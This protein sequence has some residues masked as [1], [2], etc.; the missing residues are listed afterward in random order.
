MSSSLEIA[1]SGG[2]GTILGHC[3]DKFRGVLETFIAN[4]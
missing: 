3:D 2:K 1:L 4:F